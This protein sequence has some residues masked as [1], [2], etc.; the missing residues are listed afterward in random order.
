MKK[1][2][3]PF[4][5]TSYLLFGLF[6]ISCN[7][8]NPNSMSDRHTKLE[9]V[10][11][12]NCQ[13]LVIVTSPSPESITGMMR[14]YQK[15]NDRWHLAGDMH[16]VTLGKTG[17]ANGSGLHETALQAGDHKQEGDGKS[18]SGVFKFGSAF[19]YATAAEVAGKF[20]VPY[21]HISE[22]TQCIE[23]SDSEFYNRIIDNRKVKKDWEAADFM[24]REDDLYKWGIFVEHNTPAWPKAGSCIFFHLWRGSDKH[25]AGCTGM[26]EG[27]ILNLLTWLRPELNPRLVQLTEEDY[28]AFSVEYKLPVF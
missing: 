11:F 8:S 20:Q 9:P 28:Q 12:I 17:L 22:A 15:V 5:T 6:F 7:S 18:P 27:N 16:P 21:I 24:R 2:S 23:D 10:N 25:T 1:Y 13:Q 19:G 14:R 26:E 4:L 3:I